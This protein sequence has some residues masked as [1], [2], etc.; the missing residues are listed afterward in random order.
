MVLGHVQ[1]EVA[2]SLNNNSHRTICLKS[3]TVMFF[4]SN[5]YTTFMSV[6]LLLNSL[7][8]SLVAPFHALLPLDGEDRVTTLCTLGWYEG[9][10]HTVSPP[11][12]ISLSSCVNQQIFVVGLSLKFVFVFVG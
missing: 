5:S 12:Y 11:F 1:K 9:D 10:G 7:H 8:G 2:Y 4:I 6:F 3:V